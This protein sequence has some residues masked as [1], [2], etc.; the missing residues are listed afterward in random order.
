MNPRVGNV[1]AHGGKRYA[2]QVAVAHTGF[3][4]CS[5]DRGVC[6]EVPRGRMSRSAGGPYSEGEEGKGTPGGE[7]D[8]RGD[9]CLQVMAV[10]Q[11]HSGESLV[12]GQH[13]LGSLCP[14]AY[15]IHGQQMWGMQ[16]RQPLKS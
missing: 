11:Q 16:S 2:H 1:G 15:F 4:G 9:V 8:P 5:L 13:G 14:R 7:R 6:R 10:T 12:R 3:I